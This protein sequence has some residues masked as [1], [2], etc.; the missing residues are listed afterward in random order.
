M[1]CSC[2]TGSVW[3]LFSPDFIST[4]KNGMFNLTEKLL[5]YFPQN[6][7]EKIM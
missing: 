1:V 6:M 4:D 3:D 5:E 2:F 7:L